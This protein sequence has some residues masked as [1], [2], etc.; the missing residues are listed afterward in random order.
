MKASDVHAEIRHIISG[1]IVAKPGAV[2]LLL[3]NGPISVEDNTEIQ[4]LLK[5]YIPSIAGSLVIGNS[6]QTALGVINVEARAQD[7]RDAL[8]EE[9]RICA[10]IAEEIGSAI[11]DKAH[12]PQEDNSEEAGERIA[13]AIRKRDAQ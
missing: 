8:A 4:R 11:H 5:F 1:E 7:I 12:D 6:A 13:E 2:I 9:R 10:A 3:V